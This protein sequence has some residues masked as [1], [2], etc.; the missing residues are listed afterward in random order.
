MSDDTTPSANDG[1]D[2]GGEP[3][4]EDILASIRRIIADDEA[5]GG[6]PSKVDITPIDIAIDEPTPDDSAQDDALMSLVTDETVDDVL[7]LTDTPADVLS[8]ELV[9]ANLTATS[10]ESFDNSGDVSSVMDDLV[11]LDLTADDTPVL[12]LASDDIAPLRA[13][14]TATSENLDIAAFDDD[15]GIDDIDDLTVIDTLIDDDVVPDERVIDPAADLLADDSDNDVNDDDTDALIDSLFGDVDDANVGDIEE[16][17]VEAVAPKAISPSKTAALPVS[18]TSD[19][20]L[21]LVKSLMADLTDD[22]FLDTEAGTGV[23]MGA[24]TDLT[25]ENIEPEPESETQPVAVESEQASDNLAT[26]DDEDVDVFDDILALTLDDEAALQDEKLEALE[27]ESAQMAGLAS[28]P[29]SDIEAAPAH[30]SLADIAAEADAQAHAVTQPTAEKKTSG[31]GTMLAAV[32][33]AGGVATA[34]VAARSDDTQTDIDLPS[35]EEIE[36]LLMEGAAAD[37]DATTDLDMAAVLDDNVEAEATDAGSEDATPDASV[38]EEIEPVVEASALDNTP[39]T[40]D[41]NTESPEETSAMAR[42]A[43]SA[44]SKD[45]I[46]DEVTETATAGAFAQLNNAVEEKAVFEERGDR[47]GDLVQEALR[48]MLKEWL[49]A[50]LKGIVERAVTKEVKRISSGK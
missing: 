17:V 44:V 13:D 49:D 16:P 28:D 23:D 15:F 5:D 50:N 2:A 42:T 27:L 10:P 22:S 24:E 45:T 19:S 35:H 33:A 48:P 46:L 21:D 25:L 4:M 38:K 26:E 14:E 43:S 30:K 29:V 3:S 20:D 6:A 39:D 34:T 9:A 1:T 41:S 40:H 7:E 47:I 18:S 37:D 12:D 36:S 8:P 31:N 32:L 11:D